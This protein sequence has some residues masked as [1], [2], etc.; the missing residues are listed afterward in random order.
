[1]SDAGSQQDA[2]EPTKRERPT[3][4]EESR[5]PWAPDH[6]DV[7]EAGD[8]GPHTSDATNVAPAAGDDVEGSETQR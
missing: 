2:G 4:A 5:Q 7:K 6:P 1:M 8:D 3:I